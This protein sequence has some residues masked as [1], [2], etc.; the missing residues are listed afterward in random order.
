MGLLIRDV[1]RISC[2]HYRSK[3]GA[4]AWVLCAHARVHNCDPNLTPI[5]NYS[6]RLI[7]ASHS[8]RLHSSTSGWLEYDQDSHMM[9][10]TGEEKLTEP[11]TQIQM[12]RGGEGIWSFKIPGL[13]NVCPGLVLGGGVRRPKLNCN[14]WMLE[15]QEL[16][17]RPGHSDTQT[18]PASPP[19]S[20]LCVIKCISVVP[21]LKVTIRTLP[22]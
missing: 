13:A 3:L 21:R 20:R 16:G 12:R 4:R 15:W 8:W 19:L 2:I 11:F 10:I 1:K 5:Q 14:I 9:V 17:G 22:V 6:A 18:H 7:P